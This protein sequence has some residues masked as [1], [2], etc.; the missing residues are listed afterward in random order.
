M[1]NKYLIIRHLTL[2]ENEVNPFVANFI[3]SKL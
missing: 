2:F 3:M 1:T